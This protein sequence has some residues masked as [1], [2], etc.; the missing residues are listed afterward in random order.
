MEE[1]IDFVTL[2]PALE[3]LCQLWT[4][5][6]MRL[7]IGQGWNL[8]FVT[9][10]VSDHTHRGWPIEKEFPIHSMQDIL[11]TNRC[12]WSWSLQRD[13]FP[14]SYITDVTRM[15]E[16]GSIDGHHDTE[17]ISD[18]LL[19]CVSDRQEKLRWK[20]AAFSPMYQKADLDNDIF[21]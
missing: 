7:T 19:K 11:N 12:L 16:D 20:R 9:A 4:T 21:A 18:E 8:M 14:W 15:N 5:P 6:V 17:N 3:E 13:G 1:T 10:L 2:T